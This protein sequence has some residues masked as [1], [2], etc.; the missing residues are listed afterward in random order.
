MSI[1]NDESQSNKW[2]I[3]VRMDNDQMKRNAFVSV[4]EEEGE[5]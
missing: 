4:T 3:N 2:P 5:R 1:K